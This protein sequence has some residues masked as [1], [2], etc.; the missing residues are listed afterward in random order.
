VSEL[1]AA[2]D[3]VD[4]VNQQKLASGLAAGMVEST[5]RA[6]QLALSTLKQGPTIYTILPVVKRVHFRV[7]LDGFVINALATM[8][9]FHS[10]AS[11]F[12]VDVVF[13]HGL[14]TKQDVE[15]RFPPP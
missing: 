7:R 8:I 15:V 9:F 11:Q 2:R 1:G 13:I 5:F 10:Q 12:L 4:G 3:T 14:T 6:Y